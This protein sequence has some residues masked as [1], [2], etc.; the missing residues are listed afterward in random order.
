MMKMKGITPIISIIILLLI[1][2]ALAATA[3]TFMS[4]MMTSYTRSF[5]IVDSYCEAGTTTNIKL[6]Y[7]GTGS[8]P[9]SLDN[10]N[11]AFSGG[12][13]KTCG[14]IT[15]TRTDAVFN[16]A[17]FST[18]KITSGQIVTFKDTC[19]A[20]GTKMC[21]YRFAGMGMGSLVSTVSCG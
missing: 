5:T 4:G 7:V 2:I 15:V 12:N 20:S 1:T 19:T 10:C 16:G 21:A 9:L 18:D 14:S 3:W 17:N 8:D 6:R 13:D 11:V